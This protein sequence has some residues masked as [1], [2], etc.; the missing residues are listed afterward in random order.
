VQAGPEL[1]IVDD[2]GK[3][4]PDVKDCIRIA[5]EN[6]IPIMT[7]HK[8]TDLVFPIVEYC[9]EVGAHVLVT[10]AGGSRVPAEMAG[11]VEQA[12][13]LIKMGAYLELC[14]NKCFL[15]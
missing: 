4:L 7:G 12:K 9:Q 2:K 1:H 3:L 5:A 14:G 10:H 11:T 13:E 8:T 6:K 15:I